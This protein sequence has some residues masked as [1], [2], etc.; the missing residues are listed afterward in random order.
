MDADRLADELK[1][2]SIPR[3]RNPRRGPW[4]LLAA[5]GLAGILAA[6][7]IVWPRPSGAPGEP[8]ENEP[9][10]DHSFAIA[11]PPAPA[12]ISASGYVVPARRAILGSKTAGRLVMFDAREG[13]KIEAGQLLARLDDKDLSAERTRL[14]VDR[15]NLARQLERRRELMAKGFVSKEEFEALEAQLKSAQAAL[16]LADAR[17]AETRIA[18]PFEGVVLERHCEVGDMI[19]PG[20]SV[21]TVADVATGLF[22]EVDVTENQIGRVYVGQRAKVVLD[23]APDRNFDGTVSQVF[24]SA[25]RQKG[26]VRVRVRF[27]EPDESVRI[28]LTVR[29]TFIESKD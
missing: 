25:M 28:D 29:V 26:T 7:W 24:P 3:D 12:G 15:D 13:D 5:I 4:G 27:N 19:Q 10:P 17:L 21:A 14:A 11:P 20:K 8:E 22:A 9:D 6:A 1:K 18:A 23:A 16:E 2:L